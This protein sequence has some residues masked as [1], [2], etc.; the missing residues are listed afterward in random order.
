[1]DSA[2]HGV[3]AVAGSLNLVMELGVKKEEAGI[4][5]NE[6]YHN[7]GNVRYASDRTQCR[8]QSVIT[9]Q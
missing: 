1:M 5:G 3:G 4:W 9:A 2:C 8:Q 7:D 6:S